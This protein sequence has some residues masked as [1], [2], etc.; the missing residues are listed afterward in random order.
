[1]TD[2]QPEALRLAEILEHP[3][4]PLDVEQAAA[5]ELRRLHELNEDK[6]E[7]IA[8][9]SAINAQLLYALSSIE[10]YL[11]DTLSGR[12]KPDPATYKQWLIEGIIE[13][14]NRAHAAI[15]AAKEQA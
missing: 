2:K 15:A 13:A 8:S 14:R 4:V 1:M 7:I 11:N 3:S 6:T 5:T 10:I 9:L 12:V